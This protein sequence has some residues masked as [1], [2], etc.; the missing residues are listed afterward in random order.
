VCFICP[1]IFKNVES[2]IIIGGGECF[3]I[4]FEEE[5]VGL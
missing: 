3:E 4:A 5:K 2:Y 1:E